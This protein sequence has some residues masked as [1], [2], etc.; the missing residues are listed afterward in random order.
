MSSRNDRM[1]FKTSVGVFMMNHIIA[2]GGFSVVCNVR[3]MMNGEEYA[4]KVLDFK[5]KSNQ[6]DL[7]NEMNILKKLDH[8]NVLKLKEVYVYDG[9]AWIVTELCLCELKTFICDI[10]LDQDVYCFIMGCISS[11]L[12]YL[13]G[14]KIAHRDLK[15]ANVLLRE[16]DN[17]FVIVDMGVSKLVEPNPR[18]SSVRTKKNLEDHIDMK[19][20][21]GT[22]SFMAPEVLKTSKGKYKSYNELAD[23]WSLG[24]IGYYMVRGG[25]PY[26]HDSPG[27]ILDEMKYRPKRFRIGS[28]IMFN[29]VLHR[30]LKL[31]LN[32]MLNK[33]AKF[34]PDAAECARFFADY[35]PET[36]YK[37]MNKFV[38]HISAK[39]CKLRYESKS[40]LPK[41]MQAFNSESMKAARVNAVRMRHPV[42][43]PAVKNS[44]SNRLQVSEAVKNSK[45]EP[46]KNIEL[47]LS[48][49]ISG[50]SNRKLVAN[51]IETQGLDQGN[52][53]KVTTASGL[54]SVATESS[55]NLNNKEELSGNLK[56]KS[57]ANTNETQGLSQGNS[58][59]VTNV[60]KPYSVPTES[61]P[62]LNNK[63]K[64]S[65][66]SS[67]IDRLSR[68]VEILPAES[69]RKTNDGQLNKSETPTSFINV[70]GVQDMVEK[71]SQDS[72][73]LIME[74]EVNKRPSPVIQDQNVSALDVTYVCRLQGAGKYVG[75]IGKSETIVVYSD[76]IFAVLDQNNKKELLRMQEEPIKAV[77]PLKFNAI[78]FGFI[79]LRETGE[80]YHIHTERTNDLNGDSFRVGDKTR[81]TNGIDPSYPVIGL[82]YC[83]GADILIAYSQK[84]VYVIET[85]PRMY[86]NVKLLFDRKADLSISEKI[87]DCNCTLRRTSSGDIYEIL[88][89]CIDHK[90]LMKVYQC[91][92]ATA[93]WKKS[94][95]ECIVPDNELKN[96]INEA[97]Y[98]QK[99]NIFPDL[100][101]DDYIFVS[102]GNQILTYSAEALNH[103]TISYGNEM[104][105][106]KLDP[107]LHFHILKNLDYSEIILNGNL[108]EKD[109]SLIDRFEHIFSTYRLI[110]I[111]SHG[112]I[113]RMIFIDDSTESGKIT[114][115]LSIEK[116]D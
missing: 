46:A 97:L 116:N 18:T 31:F 98:I 40:N 72:T 9:Y 23:I 67:E 13:H 94:I 47:N 88:V 22:P 43:N 50:N 74:S 71:N 69:H 28:K 85:T 34:R 56:R 60:P 16:S 11:G 66:N 64:L 54:N 26:K 93:M 33:K 37:K 3:D 106:L 81:I 25:L 5:S 109:T 29:T 86:A 51:Q 110:S 84:S 75:V 63:E 39:C 92:L 17:M 62:N 82:K 115:L 27:A 53:S 80:L 7:L 14:K 55:H 36:V 48:G 114:H 42:N 20:F 76:N 90:N 111:G 35:T 32:L 49:N 8:K 101:H 52:S 113:M 99:Q 44:S 89:I 77:L 107:D 61:S 112:K 100:P 83:N 30:D 108:S 4:A 21:V 91:S 96:P 45:I 15:M 73:N 104:E 6:I 70:G 79:C 24:I 95:R 87:S 103:K 102:I 10:Q 68:K 41:Q 65:G 38:A 105:S 19:T 59:K 57:V 78:E 12:S 58:S 1:A 2:S